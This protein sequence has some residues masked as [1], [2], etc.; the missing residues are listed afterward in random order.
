M[1][2][3]VGLV[4]DHYLI[5]YSFPFISGINIRCDERINHMNIYDCGIA[6]PL[7][8]CVYIIFTHLNKFVIQKR[9]LLIGILPQLRG[10]FHW[11]KIGTHGV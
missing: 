4:S 7:I 5:V 6:Y 1:N 11:A 2:L 3:I 9:I 10:D 8:F